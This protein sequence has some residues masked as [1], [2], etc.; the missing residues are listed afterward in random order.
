MRKEKNVIEEIYKKL[1]DELETK[2]KTVEKTIINAS[3]AYYNR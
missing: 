1:K 3:E 2:K